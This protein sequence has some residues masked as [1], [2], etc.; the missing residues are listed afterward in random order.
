M[1]ESAET[2]KRAVAVDPEGGL[3]LIRRVLRG[4]GADDYLHKTGAMHGTLAFPTRE[5][6]RSWF[7]A[8]GK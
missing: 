5:T 4:D 2:L 8:W 3:D 1:L 6:F 7:D